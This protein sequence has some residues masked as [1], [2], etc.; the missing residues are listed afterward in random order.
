MAVPPTTGE[1][2][3]AVPAAGTPSRT[4]TNAFLK[5]VIST[6]A[7]KAPSASPTFTTPALGTPSSGTLTNCTGLPVSTG[8]SGLGTNVATF[9][10][11]PSS[12]NL[13]AALTDET[14]TSTLA[15]TNAA[16]TLSANTSLDAATHGNRLLICD[17]AATHTILDDTAGSWGDSAVIYGINTSTGVVVIAADSTGTTNTVTAMPAMS[18]TVLPGQEFSFTRT[19]T[20]AWRGGTLDDGLQ[21]NSQSAAYTTVWADRNKQILHPTADNNARTFTIDSNANVPYPIG[22]TLT[23]INQINTVTIAITSD[24]MTLAGAGTTGS[25]TLAANGIATAIKV[26][27][28]GW[29]IN[30]TGLT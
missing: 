11:N 27:S 14:G 30:G 25:R 5:D 4:L 10:A 23:F 2:D 8:V 3:A 29:I 19:G 22:T 28:T 16:A 15:F 9:L 12:A 21:Q 6:L 7:L 20:N 1:A 26:S 18:L 17:T 24:T 13:R